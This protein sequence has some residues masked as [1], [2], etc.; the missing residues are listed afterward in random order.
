MGRKSISTYKLN[1]IK[2]MLSEG[3][4]SN[5]ISSELKISTATVSNY[6][7][8][9]KNKDKLNSA[10][11]NYNNSGS[12]DQKMLEKVPP[13]NANISPDSLKTS[14]KYI[15][16]GTSINFKHK[17]KSIIIGINEIIVDI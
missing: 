1:K 17:P 9:F 7:A 4:T 13:I 3:K 16:N 15:V 12:I 6:R 11:K 14:F 2:K 10:E 8:Y 5:Q